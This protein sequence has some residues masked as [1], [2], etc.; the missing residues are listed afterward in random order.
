MAVLLFWQAKS[1][2][3]ISGFDLGVCVP[4]IVDVVDCPD[5]E[6]GGGSFDSADAL[7]GVCSGTEFYDLENAV[8]GQSWRNRT[9][10]AGFAELADAF[11]TNIF[12]IF[13]ILPT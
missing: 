3:G 5:S 2:F 1:F 6:M 11:T 13:F 7:D 4:D 12:R 10:C 8:T 9:F